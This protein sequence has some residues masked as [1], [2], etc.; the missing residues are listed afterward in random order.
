MEGQAQAPPAPTIIGRKESTDPVKAQGILK[1][2]SRKNK[3]AAR[4]WPQRWDFY[5]RIREIQE[6]EAL[7]KGYTLEEY[8]A[9]VQSR[10]C[11]LEPTTYPVV[12]DPSPSPI[13]PTSSRM[14]GRRAQCPLERYGL[15]VMTP[16]DYPT[17]PPLPPGQVYDPY[18]QTM[19]FL[20]SV[21]G[22]PISYKL[23]PV[24]NEV[25]DEM[26]T[27]PRHLAVAQFNEDALN[28]ALQSY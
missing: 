10:S 5:T 27:R 21:T 3:T 16:R 6:E 22:D 26:W 17:R 20:G 25:T 28:K 14:I 11:K 19:M 7:K 18:K 1:E 15:L 12:V 9:A 23:P 2:V 24:T 13:P 4:L 8:R